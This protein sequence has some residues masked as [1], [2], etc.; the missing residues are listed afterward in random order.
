LQYNVLDIIKE[1]KNYDGTKLLISSDNNNFEMVFNDVGIPHI[2]GLHYMQK[3]YR[4]ATG[5][6]I[7]DFLHKY[8]L[9]DKDIL[10]KVRTN[11]L[12]Q[13]DNVKNRIHYFKEFMYNLDKAKIV[14]MTNPQTKI[15]SHH[16]ILQSLDKKYLQLGIAKGEIA[17]YLETFL[18]SSND[19][20][21][22]DTGINEAVTGIYRYDD[23]CNLIPFSFDPVKAEAL[24]KEYNERKDKDNENTN[25]KDMVDESDINGINED[26]WDVEI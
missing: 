21:F 9:S 8:K 5:I 19:V 6:R 14:E 26:E 11:N 2:L 24:E 22:S 7:L 12:T 13:V 17:D 1:F 20:Y 18:V 23:E 16:L 4:Q 15:R 10:D 3:N 25:D